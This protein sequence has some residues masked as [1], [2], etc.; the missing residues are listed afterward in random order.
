V[1][2]TSQLLAVEARIRE[3][4]VRAVR[5]IG[6]EPVEPSSLA[7][8][9]EGE[10][11]RLVDGLERTARPCGCKEGAV[12]VSL[13]FVVWPVWIGLR[14]RPATVLGG[15]ARTLE[16]IPVTALS[17]LGFKGAG[18]VWGRVRHRRLRA[19]LAAAARDGERG[20]PPGVSAGPSD[21]GSRIP[22]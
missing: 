17:A 4:Q 16:L 11:R 7:G 5:Y 14:R 8:L 12:G 3:L 21:M 9:S 2:Q 1:S 18:I 10:L 19:V 20:R 6:G 15:V 22:T 13:A